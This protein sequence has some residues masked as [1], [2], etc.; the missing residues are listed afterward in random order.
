MKTPFGKI[1]YLNLYYRDYTLILSSNLFKDQTVTSSRF[2]VPHRG[3]AT[4]TS[5][6]F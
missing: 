2:N 5:S 3:I 6:S 1:I 4:L